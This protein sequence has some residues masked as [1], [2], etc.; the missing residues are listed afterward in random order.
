MAFTSVRYRTYRE[1]IDA[2]DIGTEGNLRLLEN[3]E[4]IELPP[5][6]DENIFVASEL[7]ELLKRLSDNR[8]LVKSG[9]TEIQVNP[10]GDRRVNRVPDLLVLRPE[11]I[12]LMAQI[13]K[14]V[15]LFGWPPPVLVAELVSPGAERSDNYKRDYEWKKQQYEWWQI[16]EYWIIDRHRQQ[17]VI[18][19]L[20][21]GS[22]Q[23]QR[24]IGTD[25]ICSYVFPSL[26]VNTSS[27][28]AG[29]II[30]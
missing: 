1:Y 2:A 6:D 13:K 24:Y 18:F 29:E 20:V 25:P 30:K 10:I 7:A 19:T 21:D 8:R 4:V 12:E 14:S 16:P 3:G 5:E 11:H 15:I 26:Q 23:E 17:V 28:L 27:I 22:Y 9:S